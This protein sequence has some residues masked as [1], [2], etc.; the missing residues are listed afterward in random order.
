MNPIENVWARVKG[1]LLSNWVEPPVQ[2]S[3][4]LSNRVL[5]AWQEVAMDVNLFY[6]FVDS[7]PHRMRAIVNAG[8]LWTNY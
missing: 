8:G 4:E 1:I 6:N 7:M 5:N 3:D 2:T